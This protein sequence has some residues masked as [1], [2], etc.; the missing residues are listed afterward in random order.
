MTVY[1]VSERF[2]GMKKSG[3]CIPVISAFVYNIQHISKVSD[4]LQV[5]RSYVNL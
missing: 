4:Q 5:V 1:N 2:A 3:Q